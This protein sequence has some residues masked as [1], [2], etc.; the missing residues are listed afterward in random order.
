MKWS[1]VFYS[2]QGDPLAQCLL[3]SL[4]WR[5]AAQ[6][7]RPDLMSNLLCNM[8]HTTGVCQVL[9]YAGEPMPSDAVAL[10]P[11]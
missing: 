2:L 1:D 3:I 4:A 10:L 8:L 7:G 11:N 9:D 6:S 5:C